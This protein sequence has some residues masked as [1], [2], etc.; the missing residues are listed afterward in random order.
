[1]NNIQLES[2][3]ATEVPGWCDAMSDINAFVAEVVEKLGKAHSLYEIECCY[4]SAYS[5]LE[6]VGRP[7][8]GYKR[9]MPGEQQVRQAHRRAY[10][11]KVREGRRE[12]QRHYMRVAATAVR[13]R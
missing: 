9:E 11:A 4:R 12:Y 7:K 5:D 1:M 2:S 6:R 3:A 10:D 8:L 13:Q